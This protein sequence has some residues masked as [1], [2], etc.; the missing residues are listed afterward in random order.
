ML[1]V[2]AASL[3]IGGVA[4]GVIG[5]ATAGDGDEGHYRMVPGGPG[6]KL[7]PGWRHRGPGFNGPGGPQWRW[8]DGQQSGQQLTPYGGASPSTPGPATPSPSA[9]GATG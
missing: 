9:P 2:A 1:A 4:G 3:V 8:N 6:L 7:P 5:A